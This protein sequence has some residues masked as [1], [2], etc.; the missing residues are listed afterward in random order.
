[1]RVEYFVHADADPLDHEGNNFNEDGILLLEN[2]VN[3]D[4]KKTYITIILMKKVTVDHFSEEN[5]RLHYANTFSCNIMLYSL[6]TFICNIHYDG[7][8]K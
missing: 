4:K 2:S 7:R 5:T 3:R 6:V 1:L 8:R